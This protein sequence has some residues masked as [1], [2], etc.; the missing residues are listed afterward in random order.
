MPRRIDSLLYAAPTT[1]RRAIAL[2]SIGAQNLQ[3]IGTGRAPCR[4]PHC[5]HRR[6]PHCTGPG[7]AAALLGSG[8]D[9]AV[10][11][12][13]PGDPVQSAAGRRPPRRGG[14]ANW[15]RH[16]RSRWKA[17]RRRGRS[18]P[19][20]RRAWREARRR[21]PRAACPQ[22][23]RPSSARRNS[24]HRAAGRRGAGS[25]TCSRFDAPRRE[26]GQHPAGK[27]RRAGADHRFW[28]GPRR[29]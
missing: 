29:G 20:R 16:R 19:M 28:P 18:R 2:R 25:R 7:G 10:R 3:N 5:H 1:W 12:L 15:C 26:A 14:C 22:A 6:R 11:S 24:A 21:R 27:R 23:R 17:A 4:Q 13:A 8:G 9:R